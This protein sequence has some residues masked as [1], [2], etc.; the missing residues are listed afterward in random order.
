MNNSNRS[1]LNLP[2][3]DGH[4]IATNLNISQMQYKCD[5]R[6]CDRRGCPWDDDCVKAS[7][8]H[9]YCPC[10][11]CVMSTRIDL[12]A[13]ESGRVFPKDIVVLLCQFVLQL[14]TLPL[15]VS[16]LACRRCVWK[17]KDY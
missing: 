16:R 10:D 8:C 9:I 17:I 13:K 5:R 6:E 3:I 11:V 2:K 15:E 1:R 7:C 12:I 4:Y 14:E